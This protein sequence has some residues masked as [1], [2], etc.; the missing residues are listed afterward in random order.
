MTTMKPD[1]V[2]EESKG[3]APEWVKWVLDHRLLAAAAFLC[4]VVVMLMYKT[5]SQPEGGD[6][7]IYDYIAQSILRGQLPYRDVI[8]PKGPGAMYLSA[9]AMGAGKLVGINDV[10]SVRVLNIVMV[11]ILCAVTFETGNVYLSDRLAAVIAS[12]FLLVAGQFPLLMNS[13]TQ[14]KLPMVLFGM[15][16]L[17]MI[18]R[19]RPFWA[20]VFSMLSCLC[21]Q[22]GLMFAGTAFLMFS[23]YL[24]S[25][26][27]LRA[28]K[29]IAGAAAPLAVTLAYFQSRG[30]LGDLWSWTLTYTYFFFAP[31]DSKPL[32][33]SINHFWKILS[34][35]FHYDLVLVAMAVVSMPAYAIERFRPRG[36]RSRFFSSPERYKD[37]L[38]FPPIVYFVFCLINFQNKPD[39][40]PFF[41]FIGIFLGYFVMSA[42]KFG[43]P[44]LS[45]RVRLR[46][47]TVQVTYVVLSVGLMLAA[48]IV[49][50]SN[51]RLQDWSLQEQ[52]DEVSAISSYLGPNDTIY[53]HAQADLLVL[54]NRRN[55]NPYITYDAGADDFIAAGKPNGFADVIAEMEARAPKLV[56]V[57]RLINVRHRKE[58]EQWVQEHYEKLGGFKHA[59]IYIRKQGN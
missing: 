25:W 43:I 57:S 16:A 37:A 56:A 42:G 9:L 35:G 20:G 10:I 24:T 18:A 47:S 53:V 28:L 22:P 54:M 32:G 58:L 17:L 34:Y 7:G 5:L 4:A 1:A 39:L 14:P 52:R 50:A 3:P 8:D 41:P 13:G 2:A 6:P 36:E 11:G 59:K 26:R 31:A 30:A 33:E 40:I 45:R 44:R 15:L 48:L 38:L 55:L 19:D 21:W 51:Y 12:L 49:R 29:V 27:D 23:R 46:P